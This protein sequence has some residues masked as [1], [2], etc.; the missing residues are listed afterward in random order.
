LLEGE[1]NRVLTNPVPAPAQISP[2][3]QIDKLFHPPQSAES[4]GITPPQPSSERHVNTADT[5]QQTKAKVNAIFSPAGP[6]N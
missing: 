6:H 2:Q 1:I 4:S 3:E 5:E